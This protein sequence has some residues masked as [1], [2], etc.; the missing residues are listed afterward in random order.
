MIESHNTKGLI[1]NVQYYSIHDGPGIR[2]T[3][4]M[5]GCP[6]KCLWCQNPESQRLQ[7]EIFFELEKCTG[8]GICVQACSEGAIE[9][10]EGRSRTNRKKCSGT[11]RCA[12]VCP[13]E[14]RKIMG[15]SVTAKE[16]FEEVA[17][18]ALFYQRSGGGV[19]LSGGEPLA[20]PRFAVSVLK[21]CKDA[22]IHTTV[23]TCGYASWDTVQQVLSYADLVLYDFKHIDPAEH[24]RYTGVSNEL[25]LDNARKIY[26]ELA[27]PMLA[28]VPIIP[29]YNDS[30]DNIKATTQFISSELG[31]N[32][33]VHL[34]PY[35]RLGETK[36]ERLEKMDLAVL[37]EPPAEE[38][39][40][41]LQE[42]V[43]SFGLEAVLGG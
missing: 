7:R 10:F 41:A 25:I 38:Q 42:I 18:D 34:L 2:T 35:H 8:C 17:R 23:D 6:L 16:V 27:I 5:K 22:G 28:R 20:Q 4:F 12:E 30:A 39:M 3:V 9:L 32:I 26:H 33:K 21:L 13:V 15:R 1:F 40:L 36:Y 19:T 24:K 11:G 14:A 31:K 43:Q 37:I 29:T